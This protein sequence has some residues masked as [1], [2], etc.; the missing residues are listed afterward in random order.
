MRSTAGSWYRSDRVGLGEGLGLGLG[1]GLGVR[2]GL[3]VGVGL[4]IRVGLGVGVGVG[5][6]VRLGVGL[7]HIGHF[8]V[9]KQRDRAACAPRARRAAGAVDEEL[10]LRWEVKVDDVVE[11]GDVD[12]ARRD[13]GDH[14]H[15]VGG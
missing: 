13:V 7:E 15:L 2:L 8:L 10:G 4:G 6:G 9:L 5:L 3:G 11:E 12:A 14:E 1:V